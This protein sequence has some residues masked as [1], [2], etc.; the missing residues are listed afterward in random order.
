MNRIFRA[1]ALSS[2]VSAAFIL[3]AHAQV[4]VK[5]PWVRATVSQQK[6]TGAFMQLTSPEDAR[7]VEVST[8]VAGVVEIHEMKMEKEVMRMR[9]MPG[10]L[11][12]PAGKMVELKSGGY[13]I[14]LMDLKQQVAEGSSVPL[15]LV[16]E[17]KDKKR[18]SVEIKAPVKPLT[19]MGATAPMHKM[20]H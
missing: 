6:A 13:H 11:E 19:G 8:P 20:K 1:V 3:P 10:G 4:M 12:L 9:A 5:D 14:M 2:L 15:T 17:G 7:L 18:S 16:F